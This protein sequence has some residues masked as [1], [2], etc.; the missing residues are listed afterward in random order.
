M[1]IL[2]KS[3]GVAGLN[4]LHQVQDKDGHILSKSKYQQNSSM[5][6]SKMQMISLK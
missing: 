4:G 5:E 3:V 6:N 2:I 1:Y